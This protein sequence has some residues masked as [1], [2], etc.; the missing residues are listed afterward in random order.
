MLT[1]SHCLQPG[2]QW[3]TMSGFSWDRSG[4]SHLIMQILPALALGR[5]RKRWGI[6]K[7]SC[8]SSCWQGKTLD[9]LPKASILWEHFVARSSLPNKLVNFLLWGCLKSFPT[10]QPCFTQ[11]SKEAVCGSTLLQDLARLGKTS[12][13]TALLQHGSLSVFQD[14]HFFS[15]A[16]RQCFTTIVPD[17]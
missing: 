7:T 8:Q 4:S 2:F 3:K 17:C 15:L 9:S 14:F 6:Q 12:A 10:K 13:L 16:Q 11:V 5:D 1:P